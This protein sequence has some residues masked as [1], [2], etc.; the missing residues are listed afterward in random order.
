MAQACILL[1]LLLL[2]L[3]PETPINPGVAHVLSLRR[4]LQIEHELQQKTPAMHT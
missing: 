3:L 4:Q 2:L 1:L